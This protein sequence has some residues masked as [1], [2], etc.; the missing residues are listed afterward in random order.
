MATFLEFLSSIIFMTGSFCCSGAFFEETIQKNEYKKLS[1]T[2]TFTIGFS[3]VEFC[4]NSV[5]LYKGI[6]PADEVD[7]FERL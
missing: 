2:C 4:L 5:H 1:R 7:L 3:A 6:G